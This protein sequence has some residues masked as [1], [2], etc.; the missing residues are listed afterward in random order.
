MVKRQIGGDA[1]GAYAAAAVAAK[2]VVWVAIG[3]G[4]YLLPEA[5]R[6]AR[7]GLDP[8]PVLIR[9]LAVVGAVA[10]PMLIVYGLFPETVLRLAFGPE[11]V[12]ASDALF[13][14]GCAMTLLAIGYLGV[15]Y[16]LA[17]GRVAFL[18]A[19]GAVALAEI[20]LL[21]GLGIES[22]LTFA[23]IVLAL[24][25][26]AAAS[27]LALG[28]LSP[29]ADRRRPRLERRSRAGSP[30]PR[31]SGC[32]P[33]ASGRGPPG[34]V[35]E[36]GS[37][38]G[39]STVVLARAAGSLI[40]IDPHLGSDRG[41][42]EIAAD[43]ARGDAD[44]EAFTAN[45]AAAGVSDRVRHVRKLS[46]EAHGDVAG[47]LSLLYVDGAHRFGPARADLVDW[48]S[49]VVPGGTM[50]VHDSFSSVGVTLALLVSVTGRGWRYVGRTGTLAEYRRAPAGVRDVLEQL[51]EL[52]YFARNVV[53]KA[54]IL[55]GRRR[56]AERLGLDPGA[57]WPY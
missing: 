23:A 14:L 26:A 27:V 30:R 25:A 50:L 9:A 10:V 22:L 32:G 8:R 56:W 33:R 4:L 12:V 19:L 2:A 5:T 6:A 31:R 17:L 3:I 57:P 49:R 55:A 51:F 41:P 1:A 38:R 20:A 37:F 24:Q 16:M 28:L 29:G 43:A 35:V 42:Q 54:L 48:G 11:T 53:F 46:S 7:L 18:P 34:A 36:I 21:G 44:F 40:A 15:Q 45:L 13:F 39:R 52:P 47:D